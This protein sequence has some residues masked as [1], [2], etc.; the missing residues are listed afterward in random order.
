MARQTPDATDQSLLR[1]ER[2]HF[3][4]ETI[5]RAGHVRVD[6]LSARLAVS[7][8]TIRRDLAE[9]EGEGVLRRTYGGAVAYEPIIQETLRWSRRDKY[10]S[11]ADL[12]LEYQ[13]QAESGYSV[14]N[15]AE[16]MQKPE[17]LTPE[18][19]EALWVA[20]AELPMRTDFLYREPST[21]SEIRTERP[22]GPRRLPVTTTAAELRDRIYA[23]WLGRCAGCLLGKPVEAIGRQRERLVNYLKMAKAYPPEDYL[24]EVIP[25]PD[26]YELVDAEQ[27]TVRE[28][29]DGMPH[30]DDTMYTL[31]ALHILEE[32]SF[33]F[34]THHVSSKWLEHL[35]FH[36]VFTAERIAYRNLVLGLRAPET[37][38][39]RNPYR[40]FIGA[41]IRADLWGYVSVGAPEQAAEL[42]FRDASLSHTKNGLYGAMLVAAMLAAAYTTDDVESMVNI[43]LSEIPAR[44]R[45]AEAVQRVVGWARADDHWEKTIDRIWE[46]YGHY[47]PY[48]CDQQRRCGRRSLA[49]RAG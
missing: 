21:L 15:L 19:V 3:I 12:R 38:S 29:I 44:S 48:P 22:A 16:R 42:A 47:N 36:M 41:Q 39:F 46:T 13:E 27:G 11:R 30:D 26:G 18:Q 9:L 34:E 1:H 49:A 31:L 28:R 33:G 14:D 10:S 6:E 23:A 8:Y 40:E 2:L 35:P 17:D 4:R 7:A 24:S 5:R 37:A 43:G 45:L 32:H 25:L 20:M